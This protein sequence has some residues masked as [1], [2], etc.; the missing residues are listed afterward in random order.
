MVAPIKTK[1]DVADLLSDSFVIGP[2]SNHYF[3]D[4]AWSEARS[5]F[6]LYETYWQLRWRDGRP[7]PGVDPVRI[8]TWVQVAARNGLGSSPLQQVAQIS[9]AAGIAKYLNIRLDPQLTA[10]KLETMRDGDLYAPDPGAGGTWGSTAAAV[11]AMRDVGLPVPDAT[12]RQA[13]AKLSGLSTTLT[14][15]EAVSTAIP[16]L[17]VVGAGRSGNDSKEDELRVSAAVLSILNAIEPSSID[18]SWLGARYQLDSV[19]SSLGQPRTSLRPETCAKL[20]TSTGTVTLPNRVD[21]DTQGTF[22][23]RELGCRTVISQM[24]RPYTRAGWVLGSAVD[25]YE[26]LAATHAALALA[27][28]VAGDA[29]FANRLGDS[30]E[31][32]W[33]PMLKD[34][35]LPSTAHPLASARLARVADIAD[36]SVTVE[37]NTS[38]K[39]SDRYELV[40]VLVANAIGGEEQRRVDE[41]ALAQLQEGGG[42]ESMDVAAMLAIIGGHLHDKAAMA[43]AA[44]IARQNR[45]VD[46]L[47]GIGPCEERQTC[48]SAEPSIPASAIGSWIERSHAAP[49]HRWEEK[50]MCDGFLCSDGA[51]DGASLGQIYLALACDKPACGGRFPLMI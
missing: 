48:A 8:G 41:L 22:Y 46:T 33:T 3:V 13:G 28:L 26:T 5:P 45:I 42:P 14:P 47:Y 36:V 31:Q 37:S 29:A 21:A 50:G 25:P 2:G 43:R 9:Y 35:S 12:L 40:D 17:E 24:D 1:E 39:P 10:A 23:A 27:D 30:V 16:L 6:S 49:R 11:R 20:V 15:E 4:D 7:P 38:S 32:L 34:A 51:Q 19:R 18:I 44:V